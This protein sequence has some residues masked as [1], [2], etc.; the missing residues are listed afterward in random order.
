MLDPNVIAAPVT[1]VGWFVVGIM[2]ATADQTDLRCAS[3]ISSQNPSTGYH[4]A[5]FDNSVFL[6]DLWIKQ[7]HIFFLLHFRTSDRSLSGANPSRLGSP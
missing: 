5:I 2:A 7:N 6:G 3:Q 4:I 1:E